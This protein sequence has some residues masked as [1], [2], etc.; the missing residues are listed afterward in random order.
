MKLLK[1]KTLKKIKLGNIKAFENV[2]REFY[3][4]LCSFANKILK[5]KDKSEEIV[6]DIFYNIWKKRENIE[7]NTSLKS[8]LFK[9]VQNKCYQIEQHKVIENKYKNYVKQESFS[10]Y[11]IPF[12][13]LELQ[14]VN[15]LIEATLNSLPA[16]CN[17][18][19]R[20]SRFEGLKYK[21]IAEKLSISVKTVE[22]NMSKALK[23]FRTNLKEYNNAELV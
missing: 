10:N 19:F 22:A 9:S 15:L 16:N 1:T 13:E 2:F 21:E 5:D 18:I 4:V 20:M 12:D 17:T 14:E 11:N 7:I 23:K 6:Q 8:Y 3:P